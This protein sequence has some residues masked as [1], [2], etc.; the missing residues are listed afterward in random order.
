MTRGL[1]ARSTAAQPRRSGTDPE[2]RIPKSEYRNKSQ[3]SKSQTNGHRTR[4]RRAG[5]ES[6]QADRAGARQ[7]P[8]PRPTSPR[9]PRIFPRSRVG[10]WVNRRVGATE[11]VNCVADDYTEPI[12]RVRLPLSPA[13]RFSGSPALRLDGSPLAGLSPQSVLALP[14]LPRNGLS[15]SIGIGNSVVELFSAATSR[16]V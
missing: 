12:L 10:E 5:P 1:P 7:L 6:T 9:H 4:R 14:A 15:R 8:G 3:S 2:I 11:A 16:S 13:L